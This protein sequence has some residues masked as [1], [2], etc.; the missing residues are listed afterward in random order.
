MKFQ[1]KKY[2]ESD[3]KENEAVSIF[4]DIVNKEFI[5]SFVNTR[6]KIPN[7]DGNIEVMGEDLRPLGFIVV[8]VKGLNDK[9][10]DPPKYSV[11]TSF[12]G[13][14]LKTNVPVLLIGVDC[15]NRR[16]Y[17]LHINEQMISNLQL[18]NKQQTK[19]LVFP[20]EN[21]IDGIVIDYI[22]KW[23]DIINEFK[24][25]LTN[26]D[27]L[28]KQ[29][30]EAMEIIDSYTIQ[31]IG[32]TDKA[33]INYHLFIDDFNRLLDTMFKH[34]KFKLFRNC[35]KVGLMY[36][37][38]DEDHKSFSIYPIQIDT[39]DLILKKGSQELWKRLIKS[40]FG[41]RFTD[42]KN[43]F[44]NDP[45]AFARRILFEKLEELIKIKAFRNTGEINLANEYIIAFI[46]NMKTQLGLQNKEVYSIEE[47]E[48][49][50]F[51]YFP[52]W[53][54]E[55]IKFLKFDKR[56]GK[57][58]LGDD[59]SKGNYYNPSALIHNLQLDERESINNKVK[60]RIENN[61]L[62]TKE[63][64]IGDRNYSYRDFTNHLRYL[65]K[66]TIDSIERL[67]KMTG[68]MKASHIY[69]RYTDGDIVYNLKQIISLIPDVFENFLKNN[70]LDVSVFNFFNKMSK[71]IIIYELISKPFNREQRFSIHMLFLEG[72]P[73]QDPFIEIYSHDHTDIKELLEDIKKN[74]IEK[75]NFKGENYIFDK[76]YSC[77]T[78]FSE[79]YSETPL[80]KLCYDFLSKEINY[81]FEDVNKWH[82]Q[83]STEWL[84]IIKEK[85]STESS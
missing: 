55:V 74:S 15:I 83:K 61:E 9:M 71:L 49:A 10:L 24:G 78:R 37:L 50:Y 4:N 31:E 13:F 8:Q 39:N 43:I 54:D 77:W 7:H 45:K 27:K 64:I 25:K 38:G 52:I 1:P 41:F 23:R 80:L 65:K 26:Y 36:F 20:E 16:A 47:I 40:G 34:L 14:C 44:M 76:K 58:F 22:S 81:F 68:D 84:E 60:Q 21:L 82:E 28:K 57:R 70:S 46:D 18:K 33:F 69:D 53:I 85:K 29:Y 59:S 48:K 66:K 51:I 79:V 6:D 12:I 11:E 75:I 32:D 42:Y 62:N 30:E 67:Y 72:K 3:I 19:R 17:W 35:W 5:K 56:K 73:R 2:P 63:F